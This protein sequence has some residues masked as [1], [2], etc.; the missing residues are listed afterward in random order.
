MRMYKVYHED[1]SLNTIQTI[2][3]LRYVLALDLRVAKDYVFDMRETHEPILL[4][5]TASQ[6][7]DL[8]HYGFDVMLVNRYNITIDDDIF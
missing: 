1:C 4:D 2:K 7:H 8:E 6:A 3:D 5:L